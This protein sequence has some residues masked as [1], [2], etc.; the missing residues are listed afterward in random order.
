M[1]LQNQFD[2]LRR[3]HRL[4]KFKRTG[5]PEEFAER[6]ALSKSMLYLMLSELRK[7]GAPLEYCSNSRSYLYTSSVELQFGYVAASGANRNL[8][9]QPSNE[10][11]VVRPLDERT[12]GITA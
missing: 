12:T 2:R 7:L 5:T 10:A 1:S 3:M 4:I 8:L 9:H 11:A 6:M